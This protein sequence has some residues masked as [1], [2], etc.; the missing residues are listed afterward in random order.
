MTADAGTRDVVFLDESGF[1]PPM[2][3]GYA[4]SRVGQGAVVPR[5]DTHNRRVNVLGAL[6]V[7]T[8]PDLL[9]ERAT[10][11]IR[12]PTESRADLVPTR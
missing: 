9:W 12:T 5:E 11:M 3:T 1:T 6:V 8:V 7:G 2:P 4:C 10:S